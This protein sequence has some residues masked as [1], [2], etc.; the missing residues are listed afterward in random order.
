[1][2]PLL[3]AL[4]LKVPETVARPIIRVITTPDF[5]GGYYLKDA[6]GEWWVYMVREDP[7]RWQPLL[8]V[9][10]RKWMER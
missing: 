7:A 6:R 9:V 2:N 10:L 1:M 5:G 4:L 3:E 8:P